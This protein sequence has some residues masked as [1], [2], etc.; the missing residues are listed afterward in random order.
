MHWLLW[1]LNEIQVYIIFMIS[2]IYN[3]FFNLGTFTGILG[4]LCGLILGLSVLYL[5]ENYKIFSIDSHKYIIDAIPFKVDSA[6]IVFIVLAS[7]LLSSLAALYP[8]YKASVINIYKSI[9]T[10]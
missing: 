10:E 6:E 8:S 5:Q 2:N 9:R 7:M 3:I 4:T 1:V